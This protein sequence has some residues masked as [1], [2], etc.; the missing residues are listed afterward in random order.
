MMPATATA[1]R[2][3]PTLRC[4][5]CGLR[6]AHDA[7]YICLTCTDDP[8]TLEQVRAAEMSRPGNRSAQRAYVMDV[9]RWAGGPGWR[10]GI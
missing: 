2:R 3:R 5:R 7:T 9:F 1:P 8:Q 10:G 6:P 4:V